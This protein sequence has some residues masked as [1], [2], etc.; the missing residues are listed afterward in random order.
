MTR[1]VILG[2]GFGGLKAAFTLVKKLKKQI[3]AHQ[4]VEVVLIDRNNYHT[5][6]PTLYEAATT[7]KNSANYPLLK[8][9]VAFPIKDLLNGLPVRFIHDSVSAIDLIKGDVVCDSGQ[10]LKFDYLLLAPGSETN[11]FDIPGL[12]DNSLALKTFIDAVKIRDAVFEL[13]QTKRHGIKILIGGGG[14]TGVELA[15]ELQEWICELQEEFKECDVKTT[16]VE[17]APN[18]LPGFDQRVVKKIKERLEKLGVEII[19]NELITEVQKGMAKLKSGKNLT[20]DLLVWTGGVKAPALIA[21]LLLKTEKRGRIEVVGLLEC[22]PQTPDLKLYGK[23]YAIG[24]AICFYDPETQKP[25]PGVARAAISQAA[26][27]AHNIACDI[28]NDSRHK[29]FKPIDYP[30]IIPAGGKWAVAKIGPF[31]IAGFFGWVIK[32]L[33]ELNYLRSIMPLGKALK[34]WLKAISIFIKNDRLG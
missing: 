22:L 26:I 9:L 10:T 33:V 3:I 30:Y 24:D 16:I 23:V 19:N 31:V 18:I 32:L 2:A 8:A 7:S 14:S 15:G 29:N 13:A 28:N 27:A 21:G 17:G 25:I 12:K 6:T 20:F 11:Y 34:T 1:I 4:K 5:Y